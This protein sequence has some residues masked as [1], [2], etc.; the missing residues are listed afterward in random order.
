MT[1]TSTMLSTS[2]RTSTS[3]VPTTTMISPSRTAATKRLPK[4][5]TSHK[6]AVTED[7]GLLD[8]TMSSSVVQQ[9]VTPCQQNICFNGGSCF[10]VA[11]SGFICVCKEG[12]S[13]DM[14]QY[15]IRLNLP[16]SPSLLSL[17]VFLWR[18]F[19]LIT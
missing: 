5:T 3:A 8:T 4:T 12:D 11:Q 1:S 17:S 2:R 18:L 10:I 13:G 14:C 16:F 15:C 19:H 7:D 6:Q 9:L